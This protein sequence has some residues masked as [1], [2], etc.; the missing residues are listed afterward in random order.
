MELPQEAKLLFTQED[1]KSQGALPQ[2]TEREHLSPFTK[3][4][5]VV[6]RF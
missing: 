3:S 4:C 6:Q 5:K 1:G 2:Q